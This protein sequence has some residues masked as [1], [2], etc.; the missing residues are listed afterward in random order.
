L[1][2]YLVARDLY[3]AGLVAEADG[4]A[5]EAIDAYVASARRSSEFT[6]GYA[7]CLT[8]AALEAKANPAE[9]RRLLERLAEAQ[10]VRRI[11]QEMLERLFGTPAG[12][13]RGLP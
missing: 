3:L 13:E 2:D 10:P 12:R 1:A 11:A 4:L 5:G 9:A 8:I 7:R 6:S